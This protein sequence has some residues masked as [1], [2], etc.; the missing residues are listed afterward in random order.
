MLVPSP[1]CG[2]GSLAEKYQR[3][4]VLDK[5]RVEHH[6]K[7]NPGSGEGG[8]DDDERRGDGCAPEHGAEV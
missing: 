8:Q 4:D 6:V 7:A 3:E 2:G 5:A 1:S